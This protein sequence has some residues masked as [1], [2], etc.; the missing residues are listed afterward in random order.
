MASN[1]ARNAQFEKI[2]DECVK[3]RE[4]EN[5]V[6]DMQRENEHT[7]SRLH[8]LMRAIFEEDG[9]DAK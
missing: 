1:D 8:V 3:Y 4:T 9:D 2:V 5:K 7:R 6:K